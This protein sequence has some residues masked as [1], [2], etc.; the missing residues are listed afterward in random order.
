[1]HWTSHK[2]C[3]VCY[4]CKNPVTLD[5]V[6]KYLAR[7]I[8]YLG[9]STCHEKRMAEE[10]AKRPVEVTQGLLDY[11]NNISLMA[12]PD[13]SRSVEDNCSLADTAARKQWVHLSSI[14][15]KY[16]ALK[17]LQSVCATWS[18]LLSNDKQMLNV[19]IRREDFD[20]ERLKRH[21]AKM[22][23]VELGR[24]SEQRKK[25]I[26]REKLTPD[27]KAIKALT[28]VGMTEE[29]A[30]EF[31]KTQKRSAQSSVDVETVN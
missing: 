11:L 4:V 30:R 19:N 22:A 13:L 15:E 18:V 7:K 16:V 3:E 12:V 8:D 6:E 29:Q 21:Q 10:I 25:E 27:G 31:I 23:E 28:M 17:K 24:V 9:H 1:M 14:E 5:H 2:E 20:N 26:K